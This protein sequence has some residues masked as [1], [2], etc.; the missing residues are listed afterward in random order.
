MKYGF[1]C[2]I[3][4]AMMILAACSTTPEVSATPTLDTVQQEGQTVFTL[5]C[6]QCHALTPDTTVI[7]P[8]LAGIATRAAGR[9]EGYSAEAYLETSILAPKDYLVEGFADTMPTNFGKE[10][11]SEELSAVVSYLMTLK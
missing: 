11:T 3:L 10:L 2:L 6:A 8:S 1:L 5:R 4:V 7:G 9:M